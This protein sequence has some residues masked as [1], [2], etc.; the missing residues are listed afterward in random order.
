MSRT[1]LKAVLALVI[2]FSSGVLVGALGHRYF[3]LREVEAGRPP[4]RSMD[5]MRKMYLQE[6]KDRLQLSSKQMEDLKVVLDETGAKYGA[7]REKY[8]PEMQAIQDEQVSRINAL[9]SSEQQE[10]YARLRQER[11]D[12]RKKHNR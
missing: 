10:Q 3:S 7:V 6:M 1:P 9:L 12:R 8:R 5:D 4:R 2:V 11:E